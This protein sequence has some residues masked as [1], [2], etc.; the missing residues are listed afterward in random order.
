MRI[1]KQEGYRRKHKKRK[2]ISA[3]VL[4]NGMIRGE[5]QRS[6]DVTVAPSYEDLGINNKKE[7]GSMRPTAQQVFERFLENENDTGGIMVRPLK[8]LYM[9]YQFYAKDKGAEEQMSFE[10]FERACEYAFQGIEGWRKD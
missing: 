3:V 4:I 10:S 5:Y 9:Q 2:S 6:H 7:K 1:G 8:G